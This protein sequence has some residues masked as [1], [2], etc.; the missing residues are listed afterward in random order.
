ITSRKNRG[1]SHTLVPAA[2]L[3]HQKLNLKFIN[4]DNNFY[5]RSRYN[6]LFVACFDALRATRYNS[7]NV[8]D[9]MK[10]TFL[11]DFFS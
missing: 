5:F 2:P 10:S 7:S 9:S 11:R 4:I 8:K 3:L 1:H 6:S